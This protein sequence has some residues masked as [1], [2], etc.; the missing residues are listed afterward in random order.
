MV[1]NDYQVQVFGTLAKKKTLCENCLAIV[2]NYIQTIFTMAEKTEKNLA[3]VISQTSSDNANENDSEL[4]ANGTKQQKYQREEQ[5]QPQECC[6]CMTTR[7]SLLVHIPLLA[8]SAV[9]VAHSYAATSN[10]SD[11]NT[12]SDNNTTCYNKTTCDVSDPTEIEGT[13]Q[14]VVFLMYDFDTYQH[15]SHSNMIILNPYGDATNTPTDMPVLSPPTP[16][17]T[18]DPTFFPTFEPKRNDTTYY[19]TYSPTVAPTNHC[20][21]SDVG[22]ADEYITTENYDW[23]VSSILEGQTLHLGNISVNATANGCECD[24][25]ESVFTMRHYNSEMD[26]SDHRSI[27]TAI[28]PR[29]EEGLYWHL[30]RV[31]AGRNNRKF[32]RLVV[33][34]GIH[35]RGEPPPNRNFSFSFLIN[36][37][38]ISPEIAIR[39]FKIANFAEGGPYLRYYKHDVGIR[40][41]RT[42]QNGA[43]M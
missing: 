43:G 28:W 37:D 41:A 10:T 7:K 9:M 29:G 13:T 1:E 12:A 8:I 17:P 11:N 42:W 21:N 22:S 32:Y 39:T 27:F 5:N 38:H 24:A 33:D 26:D 34:E 6:A 31:V 14:E 4:G 16:Y 35:L 15:P 18:S 23:D 40:T 3:S 36:P 20:P 30:E 25:R 19:P 2:Y